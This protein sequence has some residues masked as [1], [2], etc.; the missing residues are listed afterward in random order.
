MPDDEQEPQDGDEKTQPQPKPGEM[1]E[2]QAKRLL[3]DLADQE[4]ENLR[5]KLLQQT[6]AGD[7]RPEKDW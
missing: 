5:N 1:T 7:R 6:P 4:Q 3:D 2:E